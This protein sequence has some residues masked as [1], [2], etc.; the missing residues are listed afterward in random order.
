MLLLG[1]LLL[2]NLLQAFVTELIWDE[3]YYWYY[4][5]NLAWGYFDHPPMVAWMIG[6]GTLLFDNELGV[7]L[8]ACLLGAGTVY[9]LWILTDH[10]EKEH[11]WK[12]FF[13][14][15]FSMT[16]LQAYGFFSLPDTPLLFFTALFLLFYR[17]FLRKP[18]WGVAMLL[19]ICMAALMYSKYHAALVILL[20]LASNLQLLKNRFAWVALGVSLI[21]YLPHLLWLYNHDFVSVKF[22]LFERPNQPYSFTKFTLGYLLNLVALFGF[23]FPFVYRALFRT[24]SRTQFD[25]ALLF[26]TYGFLI[27]FFAS[28]FQRHV[29]TQ[30]LIVICI[31][32]GIL[33]AQHLMSEAATRKWIW[34]LGIVNILVLGWLRVG[35][36]FQ[37][38][39][40][41][42]YE[43]HGNK[44][45]VRELDSVAR[46]GP[47]V[48]ANSYQRAS[49]YQFYSRKPSFS[50]N[51][52][53]YRKNQYSIDGSE[54][55]FRGKDVY[56]VYKRQKQGD[57]YFRNPKN[58]KVFGTF[59]QNFNPYRRLAAGVIEEGRLVP[60][61]QYRMWVYNPYEVG[62]PSSSL[63]FGIN[64]LDRAKKPVE[65]RP[66]AHDKLP[67]EDL[68][69][70][71]T[72]RFNFI[73]PS[74]QQPHPYYARAVISE[75]G[76]FWG[77][78]G[79]AKK[80][81]P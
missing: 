59:I 22:H 54:E 18:G 36:V 42:I 39:S 47:V 5:Q 1:G 68:A 3:A 69:P 60:G 66:I 61:E 44:T 73:M 64:Y 77:I 20:V 9:L 41:K 38:A 71:D 65:I 81:E 75:N 52:A 43:S 56:Y 37:E 30:W 48:F 46:G 10:P 33:V 16:L 63:Q 58:E 14:W 21:C 79:S 67:F 28:S 74:P 34:R 40:P 32:M 78:N 50:L 55:I 51:N 15:V 72:V 11:Y 8:I 57:H 45:W 26:L 6:A 2:L 27:F 7:R 24:K 29:Q 19:G 35:L 62:I 25:K 70:K 4:S 53:Y 49:I 80:I 12:E 31:P 76:L 23:T 13:V 17:E